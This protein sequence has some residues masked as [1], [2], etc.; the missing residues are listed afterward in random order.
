MNNKEYKDYR[1]LDEE[2]EDLEIQQED[3]DINNVVVSEEIEH[4]GDTQAS[5]EKLASDIIDVEAIESQDQ[6]SISDKVQVVVYT[7]ILTEEE[8][9]LQDTTQDINQ[10]IYK[11]DIYK[12]DIYKEDIYK[13]DKQD[14]QKKLHEEEL[15]KKYEY[16]QTEYK[17]E[18]QETTKDTSF[19]SYVQ[20]DKERERSFLAKWSIRLAK[21]ILF[22]MLL[23]VIGI[24]GGGILA[25]AG[26]VAVGI[27]ICIGGGLLILGTTCFVATQVNAMIIAL[28]VSLGITAISFG[29]IILILCIMLIKKVN[30]LIHERKITKKN[31]EVR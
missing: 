13:E 18:Q 16:K 26:G 11:E 3:E 9:N 30:Q 25:I 22:I 17:N 7:P 6:A 23:P 12:E 24:I 19:T 15:N 1:V 8:E 27:L 28:G 14:Y 2:I 4:K 31:K 21:L 10:D 29:M 20:A 5:L